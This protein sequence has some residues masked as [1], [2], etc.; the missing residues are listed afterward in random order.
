VQPLHAK[1]NGCLRN[2]KHPLLSLAVVGGR[3]ILL[4]LDSKPGGRLVNELGLH[5]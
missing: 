4:A 1:V 2:P 5:E 3:V